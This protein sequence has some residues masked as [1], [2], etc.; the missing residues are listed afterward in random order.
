MKSILR[1][2]RPF[3]SSFIISGVKSLSLVKP[4]NFMH[5][6]LQATWFTYSSFL[7]AI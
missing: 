4:D 2:N 6:T 3:P 5:S 1:Q 7:Y